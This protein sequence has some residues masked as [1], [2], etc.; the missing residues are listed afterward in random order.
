VTEDDVQPVRDEAPVDRGADV[1]WEPPD[2]TDVLR[3]QRRLQLVGPATMV[4]LIF[5]VTPLLRWTVLDPTFGWSYWLGVAVTLIIVGETVES[6]VS[7][8]ARASWEQDTRKKV[9]VEHA[10]RHHTSI[11]AA[12]R[13]LVTDRAR[14][15]YLWARVGF[16]GWP[17]LGVALVG[18]ML[19]VRLPSSLAVPVVVVCLLLV[20]RAVRKARLARRW[21]ADPLPRDGEE[22][23]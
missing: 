23:R 1:G 21:L 12:D 9:R 13:A 22:T 14:A 16:V 19:E 6:Y 15:M 3:R 11:G 8:E 5:V 2:W 7:T 18:R 4:L 10:L 20:G 17:F